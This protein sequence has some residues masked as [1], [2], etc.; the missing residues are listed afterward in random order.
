MGKPLMLLSLKIKKIGKV[1]IRTV[2]IRRTVIA[3]VIRGWW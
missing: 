1:M 3:V 2:M